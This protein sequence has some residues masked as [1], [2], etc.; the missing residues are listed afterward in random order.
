MTIVFLPASSDRVQQGKAAF[1][2]VAEILLGIDHGFPNEVIGGE[3]HHCIRVL[4]RWQ[5]FLAVVDVADNG[6]ETLGQKIKTG[7]EIVVEEDFQAGSSQHPRCVASD[8]PS[9]AHHQDLQLNPPNTHDST[10]PSVSLNRT[11][12]NSTGIE[13]ASPRATRL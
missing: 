7:G 3:M 12:C 1:H 13:A 8:V 10:E 4:D 11:D 5:K 9:A 6:F 2:V